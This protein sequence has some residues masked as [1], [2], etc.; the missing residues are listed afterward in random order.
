MH[1]GLTEHEIAGRRRALASRPLP[2]LSRRA[3]FLRDA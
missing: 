3:A 2:P 1:A